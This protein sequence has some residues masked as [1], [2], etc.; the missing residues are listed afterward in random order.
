MTDPSVLRAPSA[1]P[2][3]PGGSLDPAGVVRLRLVIA[4]LYR[5]LMQASSGRD[6]TFAQLSTLARVEDLG[7]M[8]LGEL[9]AHEGVAAPSMTRTIAPL[10][11]SGL[12]RKE[13]DPRDG[14]SSL[15]TATPA[16]RE[17][18]AQ[19][20]RE[21]TETLARRISR[22]TP[23]QCDALHAAVPILE[24]LL[25][26]PQPEPAPGAATEPEPEPEPR[27]DR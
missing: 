21:R 17:L 25:A 7:P 4:R 2:D 20:R 22:L 9:A 13:P 15:V 11:D 16:G 24:A 23:Q 26:E 3:Q 18:L 12:I 1:A 10:V 5:Q 19:M 6:L 14:R 27:A 8:R